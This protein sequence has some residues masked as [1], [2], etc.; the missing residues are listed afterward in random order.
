MED[1]GT[2]ECHQFFKDT[3][4]EAQNQ[5][6]LIKE[7][8][9]KVIDVLGSRQVVHAVDGEVATQ[10]QPEDGD[11]EL[12]FKL[13]ACDKWGPPGSIL[14]RCLFNSLISDLEDGI[15]C[16]LMKFSENTN[17]RGK[18]N[19]LGERATLQEDLDRLEAWAAKN[20]MKFHKD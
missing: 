20:F 7:T 11:K 2:F 5:F 10:T 9:P 4:L 13:A 1:E 18:V 14:G 8:P 3:L 12:L 19:T 15:K 6:M 17:L 16:I